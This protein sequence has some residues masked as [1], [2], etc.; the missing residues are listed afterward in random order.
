DVGA[1]G[2]RPESDGGVDVFVHPAPG[3]FGQGSGGGENGFQTGE[4]TV[5]GRRN[6]GAFDQAQVWGAHG[7]PG[8][9]GG[10]DDLELSGG[11]IDFGR[12]A[13]DDYGCAQCQRLDQRVPHHPGGIGGNV[14]AVG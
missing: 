3:G 7:K 1:A 9:V 12:A 10:G 13:V 4:V 2:V 5:F 14:V 8:S 11:A 6:A